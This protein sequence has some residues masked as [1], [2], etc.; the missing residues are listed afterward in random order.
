M[1]TVVTIAAVA[2]FKRF[3]QVNQLLTPMMNYW[4]LSLGC[5]WL[6]DK[7]V[8]LHPTCI[9]GVIPELQQSGQ[10]HTHG[11][12]TQFTPGMSRTAIQPGFL[13]Y[14]DNSSVLVPTCSLLCLGGQK[15]WL[16]GSLQRPQHDY[17]GVRY[18]LIYVFVV[19]CLYLYSINGALLPPVIKTRHWSILR[20]VGERERERVKG[21]ERL[22]LTTV[23]GTVSFSLVQK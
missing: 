23:T 7:Y 6:A 11:N 5:S 17:K 22:W 13:T 14:Q 12:H 15:L 3:H 19:C 9:T 8:V 20:D 4:L 1:D 2:W 21:R 10:A 18:K 16:D